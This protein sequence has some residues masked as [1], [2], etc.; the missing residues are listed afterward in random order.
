M[1]TGWYGGAD[2]HPYFAHYWTWLREW[3][4][5]EGGSVRD[6]WHPGNPIEGE[7]EYV[8]VPPVGEWDSDERMEVEPEAV[9]SGMRTTLDGDEMAEKVKKM[10]WT[11]NW[12][13]PKV[14]LHEHQGS[15]H[16]NRNG[17]T[18]PDAYESPE[19]SV[20]PGWGAPFHAGLIRAREE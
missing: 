1:S 5:E 7:R 18:F 17:W 2:S 4:T 9:I 11:A 15:H 14:F 16:L 13:V 8:E 6:H 20:G 19:M 10:A 3:E 12:W